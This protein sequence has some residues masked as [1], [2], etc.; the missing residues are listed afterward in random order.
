[1]TGWKP[2]SEAMGERRIEGSPR[3]GLTL[4]ANRTSRDAKNGDHVIFDLW[5]NNKKG[6]QSEK[7]GCG[8]VWETVNFI[9]M[10]LLL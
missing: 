9:T 6:G 8:R 3:Q 7:S 1:M 10:A 4:T 2:K 5:L